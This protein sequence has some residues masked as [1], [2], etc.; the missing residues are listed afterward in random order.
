M[1]RHAEMGEGKGGA[2]GGAVASGLA[3]WPWDQ[4]QA[5]GFSPSL[6]QC[7]P[8]NVRRSVVYRTF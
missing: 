6:L 5:A 2:G 7:E 1:G 4:L 3:P 8:A